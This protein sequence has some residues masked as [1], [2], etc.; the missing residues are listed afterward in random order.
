VTLASILVGE[1]LPS[2]PLPPGGPTGLAPAT[3]LGPSFQPVGAGAAGSGPLI[4]AGALPGVFVM[5]NQGGPGGGKTPDD[6]IELG[7]NDFEVVPAT[8]QSNT[9][10]KTP[11]GN[12]PAKIT[13]GGSSTS[14]V[15]PPVQVLD[16]ND[17]DFQPFTG[18]GA[19][20]D[21]FIAIDK[22]TGQKYIFKLASSETPLLGQ[23]QG[24]LAGDR[25]RRAVAAQILG[26]EAGISMPETTVAT[27]SNDTKIGSM[28][29][30][31]SQ[32]KPLN[33]ITDPTVRSNVASS[34]TKKDL[35]VF[36]YVVARMD[37]HEGNFIVDY[38]PVTKQ[39]TQIVPIDMELSFPPNN[40]RYVKPGPE[41]V[42]TTSTATPN[43][44]DN[45]PK[46]ISKGFYDKLVGIQSNEA[47]ITKELSN[48]L[49]PE[50]I[51][52]FFDRL[53][54]ILNLIQNLK[55]ITIVP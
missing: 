23:N 9:P 25:Y 49:T 48:Y 37:A 45:L 52:G 7:D 13:S 4:S 51:N 32:G 39:P 26:K 34:Q 44:Q 5:S 16:P 29:K 1:L 15:H 30:W 47:R 24:I 11:Q 33:E 38:N 54:Y 12:T 40:L 2:K 6:V 21:K 42:G 8:P 35:I 50:E 20:P 3:A 10:V 18:G 27:F 41:G 31:V 19:N 22:L 46:T 53:G 55:L 28:Q 43:L 17:Y 14:T 36:D